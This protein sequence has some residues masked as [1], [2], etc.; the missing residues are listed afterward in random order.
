MD[1]LHQF[2]IIH[3]KFNVISQNAK[4][5]FCS[6]HYLFHCEFLSEGSD[7]AKNWV[8]IKKNSKQITTSIYIYNFSW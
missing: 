6:D 7:I 3:E 8:L 2:K 1:N 4:I 5:K